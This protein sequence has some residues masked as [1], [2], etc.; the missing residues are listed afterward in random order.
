MRL[1]DEV[2]LVGGGA[3]LAFGLSDD[4][5][6]HVYL[7][8]GGDELALVDCG[9]A[10]GA[11]LER[12][13]A[14][15]AREGLD[16]GRVRTLFLTHYHMDHAGGAARFRECFGLRVF[17]PRAAAPAL[18]GGDERAVALDVAKVAGFYAADYR[19][20][21]VSVDRELDDGDRV[22]VGALEL[23]VHDTPGH[24]DGHASYLL[25]GR[26]RR[27]LFAGD[28]VFHG[29]RVVLQNIHDCSIQKSAASIRALA[30]LDFEALL[31][32]HA[33]IA[34]SDGTRHVRLAADACGQLFVP[35]N[36]V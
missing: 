20:E 3:T 24:C 25:Q 10:A 13:A 22:R 30:V 35:K 36:L 5:D 15:I 23:A 18:R 11:S 1:T 27:Y 32:G 34:L 21:P 4:P 31:P 14:N 26:E 9:M 28:A 8:D 7:I 19:F 2:Y 16:P 6:C 17:A 33:A 12:I 29:G